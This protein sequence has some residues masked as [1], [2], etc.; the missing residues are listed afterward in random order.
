[1][2]NSAN[3]SLSLWFLAIK[4]ANYLRNRSPSSNLKFKTPFEAMFDQKPNLKHLRTYGCKAYPLNP[5]YRSRF[6]PSAHDNCIFVGYGE[7]DGIY[8]I[9]DLKTK[10]VFRS[11]DVAFNEN[12]SEVK[13]LISLPENSYNDLIVEESSFISENSLSDSEYSQKDQSLG[14]FEYGQNNPSLGDLEYVQNN[15]SLGDLNIQTYQSLGD[16]SSQM[17]TDQNIDDQIEPSFSDLENSEPKIRKSDRVKT[18]PNRLIINPTEKSYILTESETPE[19]IEQAL[20]SR[21]KS[22]WIDAIQAELKSL[23]ENKVW[24]FVPRENKKVIGTRWIFKI[25]KDSENK[26]TR[27]KARLVAK[28]YHQKFGIDYNETF[29]PVVKLQSLRTIIAIATNQNLLIHQVDIDTAFLNG[30]LKDE[31]FVEP[32]PGC[33]LCNP[34][35]VCSLKKSLYGLK[36]EPLEWNRTLVKFLQELGLKQLKSDM[37]VFINPKIIIAVYVDDIIIS[38]QI[39]HINEFKMSISQRFKTKDLRIASFILGIKLEKF[40][41]GW[42]LHQHQYIDELISFYNLNNQKTV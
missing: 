1:M 30:E 16:L 7:S 31:V 38:S 35:Q 13:K 8:L 12:S 21:N 39:K 19:T 22:G 27:L 6:Q 3:M 24:E 25:K 4:A 10:K 40:K 37:C 42:L 15:L 11:R 33:D 20:N 23:S 32:P 9:L 28:G 26:P 29:A 17:E 14:D 18:Q 36:Q 34:D 2:L 5:N 41:N